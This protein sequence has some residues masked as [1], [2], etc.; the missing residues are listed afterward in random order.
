MS[1]DNVGKNSAQYLAKVLKNPAE[2][3]VILFK[4]YSAL[5][6]A[7][8]TPEQ[9]MDLTKNTM[10]MIVGIGGLAE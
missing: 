3:C 8:F 2:M 4:T 10:A 9:A 7:G 1:N 6:E 5:V